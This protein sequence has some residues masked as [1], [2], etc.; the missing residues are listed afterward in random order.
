[1]LFLGRG[2][3]PDLKSDSGL[4]IITAWV[5]LIHCSRDQLA[6]CDGSHTFRKSLSGA[7]RVKYPRFAASIAEHTMDV[8]GFPCSF[9]RLVVVAEINLA[10]IPYAIK[11][12]VD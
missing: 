8:H 3:F 12:V 1:M 11:G 10:P 6:L 2:W 9:E 7:V 5:G 4:I